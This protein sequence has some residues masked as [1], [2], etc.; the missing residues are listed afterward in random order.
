MFNLNVVKT[1]FYVANTILNVAKG[2]GSQ[3]G[4]NVRNMGKTL[5]NIAKVVRNIYTFS[6]HDRNI[7]AT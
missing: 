1:R 5:R 3:H 4:K 6:Q 2:H 7:V